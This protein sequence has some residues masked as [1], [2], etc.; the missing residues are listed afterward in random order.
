VILIGLFAFILKTIVLCWL[1]L[2]IRWTL[3]RF[4]YDQLMR[5]GWRKLLPTSLVNILATGLIVL[6]IQGAGAP[7]LNGLRVV[8]DITQ[9][10][11]AVAGLVAFVSLVLF[12]L[13]PAHKR[14]L[15][16]A[17]AAQFAA[18]LGGTRTS[19]MGA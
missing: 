18:A 5:L 17:T 14:R 9:G 8:G 12:L 16:V 11:V 1:S 15:L 19:R 13:R 3:P 10:I 4:R 6:A 7:L 2:T